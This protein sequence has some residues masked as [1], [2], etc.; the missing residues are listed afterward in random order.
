M[1]ERGFWIFFGIFFPGPSTNGIRDKKFFLAFSAYLITFW[2]KI[3]A[4]RVFLIFFIFF[5]FFWKFLSR[6]EYELN[7]GLKFFCLFFGLSHPVLA[8]K[9]ARKRFFNFLIFF[10]FLSELSWL[11]RV[12]TEF[13]TK[14]FFSLSRP[15]SSRFG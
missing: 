5:L 15:I 2:L 9:N 1:P 11:G 7:L 4:E 6:V 8:K 14:C 10:L 13:G 3:M 12:W